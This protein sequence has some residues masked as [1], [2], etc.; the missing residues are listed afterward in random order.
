MYFLTLVTTLFVPAQFLTGVYGMNFDVM[1]DL[2]FWWG[3]PFFWVFFLLSVLLTLVYFR[4]RTW[5]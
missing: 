1:P 2:H 5:V 3:Y 4:R